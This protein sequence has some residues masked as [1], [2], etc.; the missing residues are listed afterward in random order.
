LQIYTPTGHNQ[1]PWSQ[2][3]T[4][5][6]NQ[7][8]TWF[9]ATFPTPKYPST[10]DFSVVLDITGLGRGHAYVNSWNIAHYWSIQGGST[11][12][13]T[14]SIYQIPL[15]WLT[16]DGTDNVLTI[17]EELGAYNP[18]AVQISISQMRGSTAVTSTRIH[19]KHSTHKHI[20]QE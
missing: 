13:P 15:D 8:I 1:V 11:G 9:T 19:K 4:S 20:D 10:G 3:Y 18:K 12:R 14:Q 17:F 5:F 2:D 7:P 16:N 6:I